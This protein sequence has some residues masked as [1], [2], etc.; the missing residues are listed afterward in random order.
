MAAQGECQIDEESAGARVLQRRSE[1]EE[2]DHQLGK[3]SHRDSKDALAGEDVIRGGIEQVYRWRV[4]RRRHDACEQ[5]EQ[6]ERTHQEKQ[7]PAAGSAQGLKNQR[8]HRDCGPNDPGFGDK[9]CVVLP[10]AGCRLAGRR[11]EYAAEGC[12]HQEK[13]NVVNRH[14]VDVHAGLQ[15][16]EY[17]RQRQQD[18]DEAPKILCVE[19]READEKAQG[20]LLIEAEDDGSG[21]PNQQQGPPCGREAPGSG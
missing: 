10:P 9:R 20:E 14:V 12:R 8:P 16:V 11:D 7:D 2:A 1:H 19:H 15:R 5:R 6:R 18:C 17:E 3:G 21:S 13:Q 4:K